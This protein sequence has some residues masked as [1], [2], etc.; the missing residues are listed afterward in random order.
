MTLKRSIAAALALV[1][2]AALAGC[3]THRLASP[4]AGALEED[5]IVNN[6]DFD[7]SAAEFGA[8]HHDQYVRVDRMGMPAIATA[9]IT[10][11]NAYNQADPTD[12]AQG[13]FVS[14]IVANVTGLHT[15][16]DDDLTG[17]GLT[18]CAAGD[19]VAQAAPIV[20]PDVLRID[21]AAPAGF[22]NGRRLT[23][24]VIDITLAVVLLDLGVH[25]P[26][27]LIGVN[28]TANDRRFN[29]RFPYLARRHGPTPPGHD[30]D[31]DE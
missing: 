8:T 5:P 30:D 4:D 27:T 10:S 9:V 13:T 21:P 25:S 7:A 23:D 26:T 29:K 19:C 6:G 24:T 1:A 28:P 14:E 16:L 3:E 17:L 2:L 11:K 22:P 31:D 20:V 18:P 15:A 12:D